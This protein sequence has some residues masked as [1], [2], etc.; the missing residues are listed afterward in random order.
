MDL[1]TLFSGPAKRKK[2]TAVRKPTSHRKTAI[3]VGGIPIVVT[4]KKMKSLRVTIKPP[5]GEV[6]V[7]APKGVRIGVIREFIESRL[8]WI[9]HNVTEIKARPSSPKIEYITGDVIYVWGSALVL[10]VVLE[11]RRPSVIVAGRQRQMCIRDR[12][13]WC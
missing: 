6:R 4:F 5:L 1:K 2:T 10:R 8:E 3:E 12:T 9:E 13:A 11:N 7:S